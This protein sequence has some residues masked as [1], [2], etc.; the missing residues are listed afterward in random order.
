MLLNAQMK[1]V[2]D[3]G[4]HFTIGRR[5]THFFAEYQA[6]LEE[7]MR[8]LR[9]EYLVYPGL[10]EMRLLLSKHLDQARKAA[11]RDNRNDERDNY[12]PSALEA[13]RTARKFALMA[14]GDHSGAT[15]EVLTHLTKCHQ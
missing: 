11:E 9:I 8:L 15:G 1:K 2:E 3:I 12:R 7:C 14:T 13:G 5:L 10:F 6:W 4:N